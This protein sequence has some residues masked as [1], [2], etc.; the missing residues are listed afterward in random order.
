MADSSLERVKKKESGEGKEGRE[1][2]T[3]CGNEG[4]GE[5][6]EKDPPPLSEKAEEE[7]EEEEE[8]EKMKG[9]EDRE[10]EKRKK[11]L[12]LLRGK[13][14]PNSNVRKSNPSFMEG[15]LEEALAYLAEID[16]E[17]RNMTGKCGTEYS[18]MN[19]LSVA[20]RE[21]QTLFSLESF[22]GWG[23]TLG[24]NCAEMS[25]VRNV[26][27][28]KIGSLINICREKILQ[29]SKRKGE[30]F[31]RW[32]RVASIVLNLTRRQV[33]DIWTFFTLSRE[34][35]LLLVTGAPIDRIVRDAP[36]LR[37]ISKHRKKRN[38]WLKT[39][40]PE[41]IKKLIDKKEGLELGDLEILLFQD[42]TLLK[43]RV[44]NVTRRTQEEGGNLKR[45]REEMGE[46]ALGKEAE[47]KKGG[48]EPPEKK[49]KEM[50]RDV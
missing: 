34:L 6:R 22:I 48:S 13:T 45:T 14:S 39:H 18:D 38:F 42:E 28:F 17:F 31:L 44:S 2:A 47:G 23:N 37:L 50:Q 21:A 24:R 11:V 27:V 16:L 12:E 41:D 19:V 8:R 43:E 1:C 40:P 35:P 20:S 29:L 4:R 33:D 32:R 36:F 3:A 10:M 5:C 7:E 46:N 9:E 25:R 26:Q 30:N 49:V 15:A